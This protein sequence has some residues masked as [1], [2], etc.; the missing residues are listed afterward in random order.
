VTPIVDMLLA[1]KISLGIRQWNTIYCGNRLES[2]KNIYKK[3]ALSNEIYI[4]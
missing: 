2:F 3:N 4:V 1:S